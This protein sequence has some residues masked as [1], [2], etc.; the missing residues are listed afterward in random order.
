MRQAPCDASLQAARRVRKQSLVQQT[1][2]CQA[3]RVVKCHKSA[4]RSAGFACDAGREDLDPY[5]ARP[6]PSAAALAEKI[7]DKPH[8][9]K[10]CRVCDLG[11]GLG[12]AGIAAALA[13][14]EQPVFLT[15]PG[16]MNPK[17][18]SCLKGSVV[19]LMTWNCSRKLLLAPKSCC[20]F[21]PRNTGKNF[22][23]ESAG[24]H[25][26]TFRWMLLTPA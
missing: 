26:R 21:N 6:W 8:L 16:R 12:I 24:G 22:G 19:W 17:W 18:R 5:W 1:L 23:D 9:V 11:A 2:H 3:K 7:I 4:G 10:G 15:M 25:H 20:T 13:G 14:L